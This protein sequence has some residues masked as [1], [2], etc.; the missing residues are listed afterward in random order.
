MSNKVII[1]GDPANIVITCKI[2]GIAQDISAA[3]DIQV[4][5]CRHGVLIAQ[6]TAIGSDWAAGIIIAPFTKTQTA[7]LTA[8]STVTF[9]IEVTEGGDPN[10]WLD[11]HFTPKTAKVMQGVL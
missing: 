10:S 11:L 1:M 9:E 3:T 5:L 7:A 2:G 8:N 4:A 6:V